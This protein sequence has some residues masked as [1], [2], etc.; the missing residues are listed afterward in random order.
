MKLLQGDMNISDLKKSDT[1]HCYDSDNT[2]NRE[3]LTRALFSRSQ[4]Q[5]RT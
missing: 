3:I 2:V 5:S 1:T 4:V